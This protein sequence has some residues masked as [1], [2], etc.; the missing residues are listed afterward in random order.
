M[1]R[2]VIALDFELMH[3]ISCMFSLQFLTCDSLEDSSQHPY[4]G[5]RDPTCAQVEK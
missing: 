2:S 1:N 5:V 4:R 3:C